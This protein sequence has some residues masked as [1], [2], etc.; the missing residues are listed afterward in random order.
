M[1]KMETSTFKYADDLL[2]FLEELI[3]DGVGQFS[4]AYQIPTEE[5]AVSYPPQTLTASVG[6]SEE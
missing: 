2:A 1:S 4:A 3:L 6:L 5:W